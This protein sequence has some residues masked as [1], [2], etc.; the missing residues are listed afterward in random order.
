MRNYTVECSTVNKVMWNKHRN[1][2]GRVCL[3]LYDGFD[4]GR[5]HLANLS[6]DTLRELRD[7]N[8]AYLQYDGGPAAGGAPPK[9]SGRTKA[10]QRRFKLV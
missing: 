8:S 6:N 9:S 4:G 10:R 2:P 3:L 1:G 5:L 7:C